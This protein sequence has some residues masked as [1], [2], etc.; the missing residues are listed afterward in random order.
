MAR[1]DVATRVSTLAAN[2]LCVAV[3]ASTPCLPWSAARFELGA[4]QVLCTLEHPMGV[5]Q[6]DGGLLA[7]M[8]HAN[9]NGANCVRIANAA[10][11]R[12]SNFVFESPVLRGAK[13][14]FA[15]E[16]KSEHVD[17]STDDDTAMPVAAASVG[18]CDRG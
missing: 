4:P 18:G 2:T 8:T 13:G 15:I 9:A 12:S 6:S 11:M 1:D 3:V 16:G 7:T 14:R 5:P 10:H 17:M